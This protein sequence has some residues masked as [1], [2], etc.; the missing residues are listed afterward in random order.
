MQTEIIEEFRKGL[1]EIKDGVANTEKHVTSLT[2]AVEK[3]QQ[4]NERIDA[5]FTKVRRLHLARA[6][7]DFTAPS[8]GMV[9]DDCA[10]HVGAVFIHQCAKSGKLELVSQS[11]AVRDSLLNTSRE[12]LGMERRTALTTTDIPGNP[13]TL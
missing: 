4:E 7:A 1:T 2:M 6:S 10:R 12:I 3:L 8:R 9:S 11:A 13:E 5:E